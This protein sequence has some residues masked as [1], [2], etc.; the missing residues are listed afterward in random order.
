MEW[1]PINMARLHPLIVHL[2]IGFLI[3]GLFMD[4]VQRWQ[5]HQNYHSAI[6]LS[7]IIGGLSAAGAALTGWWLANEGGYDEGLLNPHR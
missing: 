6:G 5:K 7:I 1:L 3:M 2:P 4:V